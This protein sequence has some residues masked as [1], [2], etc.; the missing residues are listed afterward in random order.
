MGLLDRQLLHRADVD[1]VVPAAI[2]D[3]RTAP[4]QL[5]DVD[6]LV[7]ARATLADRAKST[8]VVGVRSG[9]VP[10]IDSPICGMGSL[11]TAGPLAGQYCATSASLSRVSAQRASSGTYICAGR[12]ALPP[13]LCA[14][15]GSRPSAT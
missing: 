5:A 3:R 13:V 14:P 12:T 8:V 9:A 7:H 4:G 11:S 10:G 2:L 15:T 1:G 6:E